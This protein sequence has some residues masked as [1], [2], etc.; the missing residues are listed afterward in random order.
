MTDIPPLKSSE[1]V[2][3]QYPGDEGLLSVSPPCM[4]VQLA[5][6][7]LGQPYFVVDLKSPASA[8][9]LSPTGRVPVLQLGDRRVADSVAILDVLEDLHPDTPLS[10]RDPALRARDRL[11]EH[12]ATDTLYWLGLYMR[13]CDPA[14]ADRFVS[15]LVGPGLSARRMALRLAFVPMM[16]RRARAQGVGTWSVE[17]V[18][19]AWGRALQLVQDGLGGAP[20]LSGQA[21]PGRGD[22]AIAAHLAQAGYKGT[23]PDAMAELARR[24]ALVEHVR[25]V[26][27]ACSTSAPAWVAAA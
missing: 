27:E 21:W 16:R 18:R 14:N 9:A 2:L 8:R 15:A 5:L 19:R 4:K 24:R 6:R 23:V 17:E 7:R 11:W 3:Y 10:P 20:F 12:Y 1:L 25:R 22:L 26:L 13:W